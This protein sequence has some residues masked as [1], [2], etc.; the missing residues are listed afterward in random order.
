MN[1]V[2]VRHKLHS[3]PEIAFKEYKT[4]N[5]IESLLDGLGVTYVEVAGTGILAKWEGGRGPFTLFRADMDALPVLER[6][7][8]EFS[9]QH[10]GFMHACGHD[11]HMTIL[12]GLIERVV[13]HN[14]EKNLLFLFQPAEEAGGGAERC[15]KKLEEYE[16]EEAWAL[17]VSD[18][19]PEGSVNTRAGVLFASAYEIDCTFEGRAAHVAFYKDG[20]DAIVGAMAFLEEVYKTTR[21]S[22]VLRFGLVEGG[23]VRNV[24]ADLCT[25]Y[26]TIRT[27]DV[28]HSE[29]AVKELQKIGNE[30]ARHRELNYSQRVGSKYP[31][32]VVNKG[33]YEKLC[34]LV[35]VN[36][37]PMAYTGE[38]FAFISLEYPSLMFWLGTG[39]D[40][41]AG[42]HN[43][44][45]LPADSV[46][47]EG[48]EVFW[49]VI[50][51]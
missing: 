13:E 4:Q 6:T 36:T 21:D 1:L 8:C 14:L 33:L 5:Y 24:V 30:V 35:E 11:V 42:L 47:E 3:I 46:I 50:N 28:K 48:V 10:E 27:G 38:D 51:D 49:K 19:Y 17:H 26:G 25:L 39:R 43:S 31:Q 22:T 34:R 2:E 9:S 15:L 7:N 16:I 18:E 45:F 32:L 44:K 37:V 20:R 40:E 12:I 29:K 41:R 23:R